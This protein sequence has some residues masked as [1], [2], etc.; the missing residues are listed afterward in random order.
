[1][2]RRLTLPLATLGLVMC[3]QWGCGPSGGPRP[4]MGKVHGKVSYKGA[5]LPRGTISFSP[6]SGEK[7]SKT[8]IGAIGEIHSDGTFELTTF[9]TGDGAVL[10][11]HAVTISIQSEGGSQMKNMPSDPVE[12]V[13]IAREQNLIPPIYTDPSKTPLKYTVE[14]GDNNFDIVLKD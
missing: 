9:D 12:S 10:G 2:I 7:G 11:Q 5:P 1:M 13:K 14:S 3:F 6:V 4:P 8:G